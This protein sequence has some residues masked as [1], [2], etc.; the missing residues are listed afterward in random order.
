MGRAIAAVVTAFV[1]WTVL[2]LGF[3]AGAQSLFPEIVDPE[4]PLVHTGA[5]LAYVGWS[6][7]IST[8]A[9]WICAA[10]RGGPN[11]MKTVWVFA[12]IQLAVGIG[13][14]ISYW[15]MTPVWY[16]LVFLVLIVP[17]TV[18]GGTLRGRGGE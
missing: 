13:V 16:H 12:L 11:A 2:W 10:V 7:V 6:V 4:Q 3:T 18:F 9:G 8:L 5:L 15:A 14:E 1:T 17:A